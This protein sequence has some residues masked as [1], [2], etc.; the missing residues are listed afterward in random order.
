MGTARVWWQGRIW[1]GGKGCLELRS[2]RASRAVRFI[3]LPSSSTHISKYPSGSNPSADL[4]L[5]DLTKQSP[6]MATFNPTSNGSTLRANHCVIAPTN[7]LSQQS[8]KLASTSSKPA[9]ITK[10]PESNFGRLHHAST[11]QDGTR[12]ISSWNCYENLWSNSSKNQ[13]LFLENTPSPPQNH[14][15][16]D[17]SM[18]S[19]SVMSHLEGPNPWDYQMERFQAMWKTPSPAPLSTKI[20]TS[21]KRINKGKIK[22]LAQTIIDSRPPF[23]P[24]PPIKI[25]ED[26][27]NIPG[28]TW[29]NPPSSPPIDHP[30]RSRTPI[31]PSSLSVNR[32]INP[33]TPPDPKTKDHRKHQVVHA[34]KVNINTPA[35]T[36]NVTKCSAKH[37]PSPPH[38]PS[39]TTGN[40]HPLPPTNSQDE[41]Y[42]PVEAIIFLC[43]IT[44]TISLIIIAA[45]L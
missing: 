37:S 15:L 13:E 38:P 17:R 28:L 9:N 16:D 35:F 26:P 5:P 18:K 21:I 25:E 34:D 3:N 19:E 1:H 44:C 7:P 36:I 23:S 22:D 45:K 42:T 14:L 2:V 11:T 27:E 6:D 24:G 12:P 29:T 30:P 33:R 39:P 43:I 20:K 4:S 41:F 32:S 31:P 10:S 8:P 40:T